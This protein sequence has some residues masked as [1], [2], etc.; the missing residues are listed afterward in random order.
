MGLFS[1][2]SFGYLVKKQKGKQVLSQS[3]STGKRQERAQEQDSTLRERERY[4][5]LIGIH[6]IFLFSVTLLP[7][8]QGEK[9]EREG[10]GEEEG[11][12]EAANKRLAERVYGAAS[13]NG[14]SMH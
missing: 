13:K 11:E 6:L 14:L 10:G 5:E 4:S 8:F 3:L 12:E 2:L 9:R 1:V 7:L